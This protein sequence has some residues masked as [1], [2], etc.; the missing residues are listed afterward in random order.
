MLKYFMRF[1]FRVFSSLL[2][3]SCMSGMHTH[4]HNQENFSGHIGQIVQRSKLRQIYQ[5]CTEVTFFMHFL[6]I[7]SKLEGLSLHL[8]TNTW[9]TVFLHFL[10]SLASHRPLSEPTERIKKISTITP[11]VQLNHWPYWDYSSNKNK[12]L[13]KS[14]LLLSVKITCLSFQRPRTNK[15][16]WFL[17][18]PVQKIHS[19]GDK[20]ENGLLLGIFLGWVIPC[21]RCSGK[22]LVPAE[23]GYMP[24]RARAKV[25][26]AVTG[27]MAEDRHQSP[28]HLC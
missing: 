26:S 13:Q 28:Q 21:G 8:K 23:Q 1:L 25:P 10:G 14:R 20:H 27:W 24:M 18:W 22:C 7:S 5:P 12:Y 17:L 3:L 9:K 11:V 6:C 15:C 4:I 19:V 2:H 16:W